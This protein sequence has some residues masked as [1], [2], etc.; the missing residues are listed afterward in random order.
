MA[1]C[2]RI[3]LK[4]GVGLTAVKDTRFKTECLTVKFITE[5][6]SEKNP[7]Y[8][9]LPSVLMRGSER[10]PSFASLSRALEDTYDADLSYDCSIC[11]STVFIGFTISWISDR[12]IDEKIPLRESAIDI[13]AQMILYP[14]KENGLLSEKF[15]TLEKNSLI[16]II[17][18]ERNNKRSYS[19][20]ECHKDMYEGSSFAVPK[21]G[22]H[23]QVNSVNAKI[24]TDF[25]SQMLSSSAIEF[26]YNGYEEPQ[27]IIKLIS[28]KFSPVVT[29]R[30]VCVSDFSLYA[31]PVRK[32]F[33]E[34]EEKD[35]ECNQTNLV[36]GFSI[37]SDAKREV[38]ML[39]HDLI[40][41]SPSSRLFMN[42]RE[43]Y[44]ICYDCYMIID[45]YKS[46]AFIVS[47]L[48]YSRRQEAIDAIM[49]EISDIANGNISD[50]EFLSSKKS[51][52]SALRSVKDSH[53]AIELRAL[54]LIMSGESDIDVQNNVQKMIDTVFRV[55]KEEI[56]SFAKQISLRSVFTLAG[57]KGI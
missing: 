42:V 13:L 27:E 33:K 40:S 9:M 36:M 19:I 53:T 43:K 54:S 32:E 29:D 39:F 7:L 57:G 11:G 5:S 34:R 4:Q 23:D 18:S 20:N 25:Y 6:D 3:I 10:Y 52:I 28:D 41:L 14:L 15:T 47:G 12:Y 49:S 37:P 50:S 35:S 22:T 45:R 24:L 26:F 48:E 8:F 16:D 21:H 51:C 2:K 46:S 56:S 55:T 30:D 38:C 17:R 31:D 1:D 44:G